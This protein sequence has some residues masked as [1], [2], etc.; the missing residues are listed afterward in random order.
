M[1]ESH[2]VIGIDNFSIGRL[3]NIPS[4]LKFIKA[5]LRDSASID[6]ICKREKP[7]IVY[8]L[9]AWAHEGLSQFSPKLITEN[10]YNSSLNILVA[11]IQSKV[12]KFVY[13]S[14]MSVYGDQKPPFSEDMPRAPVDVY[15]IA[16][17][18]TENLIEV[19]SK[20]YGIKYAIIR[21]HNVFGP[22]QA[23]WDPY[24][25]VLGI[26]INRVLNGLPPEIFGD[27]NQKRAFTYIDDFTKY[28]ALAGKEKALSNKIINVGPTKT[29]SINQ[30]AEIILEKMNSKLKPKHLADRPL[31]VKDA[32][33]T[34]DLAKKLLGYKTNTSFEEGIRKMIKWATQLG[35]QKFEYLDKIELTGENLPKPWV[36]K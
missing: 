1:N 32:H 31:E 19:M 6:V 29:Y 30:V 13:T 34:N 14:S 8:H 26:F 11:S 25:N 27:G 3:E 5:D 7:E 16:K 4:N 2:D 12:K 21:P 18:S 24:R 22:R 15:G 36:K 35:P 33:C 9:A 17:A 28:I 23:I 20:V 10:N